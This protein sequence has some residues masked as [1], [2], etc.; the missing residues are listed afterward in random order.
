MT[1]KSNPHGDKEWADQHLYQI[2]YVSQGFL[3]G[4]DR[5]EVEDQVPWRLEDENPCTK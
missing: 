5:L 3:A 4:L 2:A 1:Y